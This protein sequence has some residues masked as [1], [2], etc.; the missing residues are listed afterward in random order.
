M[1]MTTRNN[2][3][4]INKVVKRNLVVIRST[5]AERDCQCHACIYLGGIL[6]CRERPILLLLLLLLRASAIE[7]DCARKLCTGT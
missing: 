4:K 1:S 6:R 2:A 7:S 3:G 5:V